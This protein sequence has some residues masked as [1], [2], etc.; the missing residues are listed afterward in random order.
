MKRFEVDYGVQ[1]WDHVIEWSVW[2][3]ER[4]PIRS[5]AGRDDEAP[6]KLDH[7]RMY[8]KERGDWT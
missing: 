3:M 1:H 8:A 5:S 4:M 2:K 7:D 6:S